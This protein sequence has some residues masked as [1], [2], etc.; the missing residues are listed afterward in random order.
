MTAGAPSLP[1]ATAVLV[2]RLCRKLAAIRGEALRAQ[3]AGAELRTH[4]PAELA[5]LLGQL[6]R[7]ARHRPAAANAVT[8]VTRALA[9]GEIDPELIAAAAACARSRADRLVEALL[10][11]GPAARTYDQNEEKFVDRRMRALT[12]GERRALS[13]SRDIDLLIR[14]AHDQDPRV[15]QQLLENPRLTERE[16]IIIASRRPTHEHVLEAVLRSRFGTSRR[17][18]RSIAHNPYAS[19]AQ[20][21]RALASLTRG[22]LEQVALDE[23]VAPQVRRHA[24]SLMVARR[25][26][27]AERSAAKDGAEPPP[28]GDV[29]DWLRS[30]DA[31][32]DGETVEIV[33]IDIDGRPI[34][35]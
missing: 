4:A 23:H 19:V 9:R 1:D 3:V 29:Q 5:A 20:A 30:L 14:L 24:Q 8:A 16:V 33:P 12:L 27:P 35:R 17:V 34:E 28:S 15:I 22:E 18:R 6:L 2:Q 21:V 7:D 13:R 26:T 32:D 31:E 25:P 10:A 11:T